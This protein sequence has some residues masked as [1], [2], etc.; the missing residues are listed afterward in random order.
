[1]L[2][3]GEFHVIGAYANKVDV[4]RAAEQEHVTPF[5]C[6]LESLDSVRDFCQEVQEYRGTKTLDRLVCNGG[7]LSDEASANP[8][9][10]KDG[11]E[12]T[13]QVNFLSQF[14]VASKCIDGM[15]D[16]DDAR[17]SF[18]GD[19]GKFENPSLGTL[20]GLKEGFQK[21]IAMVDGSTDY[22]GAKACADSVLCQKQ[23]TNFLHT[24]Y[25]KL[26]G[27]TFNSVDA[28]DAELTDAIVGAAGA[29]S[30]VCLVTDENKKTLVEEDT[31]SSRRAKKTTY[32]IDAAFQLVQLCKELTNTE[33]PAIKQVTS[34]CPTLK[35]IGAITK[36][37]VKKEELKRMQQGRPGI[38]EAKKTPIKITKR[39]RASAFAQKVV[40]TVLGQTVGRVARLVGKRML[41]KVPETALKG[42]Y[43]ETA[44][45]DAQPLTD[46]DVAEIHALITEQLA[47]ESKTDFGDRSKLACRLSLFH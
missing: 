22:N 45:G 20:Q 31:A 17:I 43:D 16:S 40:G 26:T 15:V 32:D 7:I 8:L 42:S 11:Y 28:A 1:L 38:E 25:H 36:N 6:D 27:L 5:L 9:F 35:V 18:V 4:Q 2:A 34:P 37:N 44:G 14:L 12:K 46:D 30:G 47:R 13:F 3:T 24:K 23:L 21:P 10:S 39:Q 41:G 29:K 19:S 33:W